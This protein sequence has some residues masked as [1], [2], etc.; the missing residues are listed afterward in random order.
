M[1]LSEPI[2]TISD[3]LAAMTRGD[4]TSEKLTTDAL[5]KARK[6]SALNIFA[7]LDETG[8][9]AASRVSD[10][11]RKSGDVRPLQL[12]AS[13]HRC[14]RKAPTYQL[15]TGCFAVE[16]RPLRWRL[17]GLDPRP[18]RFQKCQRPTLP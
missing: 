11:R 9:L 5:E 7:T 17:P 10:A 6:L 13:R 4:T 1:T 15:A 16:R 3:A 2:S 12:R 14:Q 18:H 8:A